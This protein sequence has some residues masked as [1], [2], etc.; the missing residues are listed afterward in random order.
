MSTDLPSAENDAGRKRLRFRI[1]DIAHGLRCRGVVLWASDGVLCLLC[2]K[3]WD[4]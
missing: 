1:L 4:R 2:G 3:E